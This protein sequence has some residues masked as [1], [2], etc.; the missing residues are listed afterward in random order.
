MSGVD[1]PERFE[2]V[3]IGGGQA[4]LAMGHHLVQRGLS[5]VILD[6]G[7]RIGDAWRSRWDGL[8]LFTAGRY[9]GLPGMPFPGSPDAFPT[10]D[11]VA[12][13]LETYAARTHLP[14][15][16]GITVDD[17]WRTD[18]GYLITAG[19][20]TFEAAQVVV[21]TGAYRHPRIPDFATDL[22]PA[23]TQLH[24]SEY[25]NLSQLRD[26]GVLVV[27]ASNSGAEIALQAAA[28][29]RTILVGPD[30]GKMPIRP[31]SRLARLFDVPFWFF[32]NHVVTMDTPIGRKA[33]PDLR[34]HGLP[35]ERVW[36]V[37]LAAAGVERVHA[38]A[39]GVRDGLPVLDDGR[40]LDLATVVWSTGFRP[41]FGWI[42]LPVVGSDEWPLQVRGVVPS[43]PGLYFLGLPFLY[44]AASSLIGGVGRD[45]AYIAD[46]ITTRAGASLPAPSRE[47][48][49]VA[50]T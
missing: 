6:A 40:V 41:E 44:S 42:H 37:D 10:K 1:A 11:D 47:A 30:R 36:P 39:V 22:D 12:E 46:R 4:G 48:P 23:I 24:S 27:G 28:A 14:V 25:R 15:R 34:D 21:A 29:H 13:Y 9:D 17:V 5:F 49:A 38:R 16:T 33:R 43:A 3:V 18:D 19:S 35:L 31:E 45:A 50:G 26:G 20:Q 7:D 8:R 32:I 2:V